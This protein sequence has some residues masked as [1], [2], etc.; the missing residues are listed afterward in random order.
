MMVILAVGDVG[1][2]RADPFGAD[3]ILGHVSAHD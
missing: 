1:V 3:A 2:K